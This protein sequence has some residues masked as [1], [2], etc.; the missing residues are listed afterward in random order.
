MKIAIIGSQGMLGRD[1]LSYLGD[2]HEAVGLDIDEIDIR[3]RE[4]TVAKIAE[5]GPQLIINCAACV[6]VESCETEPEKLH[7]SG[8]VCILAYS[9]TV[10]GLV[11]SG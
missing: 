5:L 6:D 10:N 2:H 7:S 4:G 3:E 11:C 1:L 9:L 8:N